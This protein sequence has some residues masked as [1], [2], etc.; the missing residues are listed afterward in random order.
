MSRTSSSPSDL[1]RI[2][3]RI[4]ER[5]LRSEGKAF[6]QAVRKSAERL[7]DLEERIL[8]REAEELEGFQRDFLAEKKLREQRIAKQ[9]RSGEQRPSPQA[10]PL[11][12]DTHD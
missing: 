1:A 2:D 11:P 12:G 7:P 9:I 6:E 4:Q 5:R 8:L 3:K 10:E